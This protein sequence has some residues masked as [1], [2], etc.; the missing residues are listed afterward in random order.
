M[1]GEGLLVERSIVLVKNNQNVKKGDWIIWSSFVCLFVCLF[2]L[3]LEPRGWERKPLWW[4]IIINIKCISAWNGPRT[5][6]PLPT[7]NA[8]NGF[9]CIDGCWTIKISRHVAVV[10]ISK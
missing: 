3:Y 4:I 8:V 9:G 2:V 6:F 5:T 7:R 1:R 10:I